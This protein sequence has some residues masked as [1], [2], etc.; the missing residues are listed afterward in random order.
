MTQKRMDVDPGESLRTLPHRHGPDGEIC[1]DPIC[2]TEAGPWS[3]YCRAAMKPRDQEESE[4]WEEISPLERA[5]AYTL[6]YDQRGRFSCYHNEL[7]NGHCKPR[8][9]EEVRNAILGAR[10]STQGNDGRG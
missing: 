4:E 2:F 1:T 3:F 6:C 10:R 9:Y 5:Y 8:P 7:D